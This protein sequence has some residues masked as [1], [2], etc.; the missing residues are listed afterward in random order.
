[1]TVLVFP[2]SAKESSDLRITVLVV[3]LKGEVVLDPTRQG[4]IFFF[5]SGLN[6][7]LWPAAENINFSKNSGQLTV[8][9]VTHF[10]LLR[11]SLL[12]TEEFI[13]P[14]RLMIDN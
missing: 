4:K 9:N 8:S 6:F 5:P 2:Y 14:N 10:Y 1:M 3:L 7:S 13:Q 12:Y 11:Y